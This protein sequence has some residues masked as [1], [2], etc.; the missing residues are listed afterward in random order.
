MN[1]DDA[2]NFDE[3]SADELEAVSRLL[4]DPAVWAE[5][6]ADVEDRVLAAITAESQGW[7]P[8]TG[9]PRSEQSEA[10]AS[11]EGDQT[12][13]SANQVRA[14]AIADAEPLDRFN[15]TAPV[16]D[17]AERPRKQRRRFVPLLAAAAL[18]IAILGAVAALNLGSDG[19]SFTGEIVALSGT[20]VAPDASGVARLTEQPDGVQ[21][22][23]Q[24][25]DLAPAP[26]GF[27][28]EAWLVK[29]EPRTAIGAGSF[30]LR[31]GGTAEIELWSGVSITDYPLVTVTLE[32]EADPGAPGQLVLVGEVQQADG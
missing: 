4:R 18:V 19:D 3:P 20:E 8:P 21:I 16:V 17:I 13:R 23:L 12:T 30:H 22:V 14:A 2:N 31:G 27:F 15:T 5:P 25:S 32:S 1:N 28:Y 10:T 29:P 7:Q 24:V 9:L 26:P 6:S 11:D